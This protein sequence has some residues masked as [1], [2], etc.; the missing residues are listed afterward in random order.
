LAFKQQDANGN[1][2]PN[3]EIPYSDR[4]NHRAF[5]MLITAWGLR[6]NIFYPDPQNPGKITHWTLYKNGQAFRDMLTTL[7]QWWKE[8]LMDPDFFTQNETQRISKITSDLVGLSYTDPANGADWR[9]AIKK[10]KPELGDKVKF[11]GLSPI[12]GP[13]G[14]PYTPQDNF[15]NPASTHEGTAITQQA[16]K[17]GKAPALL[18]LIDYMYSDEGTTLINYG[19]EGVSFTKD[20]AGKYA[21]TPAISTDPQFPLKTKLMQYNLSYIGG[22]P[23]FGTYEAWRI[24]NT[25]DP[26]AALIHAE[27][28]KADFGIC[29]PVVTLNQAQSEEY[30]RIMADIN[31]AV[32]EFYVAVIT[33]RRPVSDTTAFYAQLKSMGIDRAQAI[34]QE[35]YTKFLAM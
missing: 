13:E 4:D 32:D 27:Y 35:A 17:K 16:E 19:V 8:G 2:N 14:K 5:N 9:D 6:N 3:D 11:T 10:L 18:K 21:W 33:G 29:M 34:Y 15:V 28:L 7:A 1:G 12:I 31:T 26:D 22:F 25:Y 23:K 20:A 30:N 24:S